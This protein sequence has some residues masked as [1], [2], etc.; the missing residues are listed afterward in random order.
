M[1]RWTYTSHGLL[2]HQN[3]TMNE[4]VRRRFSFVYS[5]EFSPWAARLGADLA[6]DLVSLSRPT[7]NFQ[8]NKQTGHSGITSL[9]ISLSNLEGRFSFLKSFYATYFEKCNT[10]SLE[11]ANSWI[12]SRICK[13]YFSGY[14]QPSCRTAQC[15]RISETV[16]NIDTA[17]T[18]H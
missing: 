6:A 17:T 15:H 3:R 5:Y 9:P 18:D 10:Y 13:A 12:R 1:D 14:K 2:V 11:R 16:W 4:N 8:F 7:R